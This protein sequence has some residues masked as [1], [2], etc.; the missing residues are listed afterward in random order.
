M[1][2][3]VDGLNG[4]FANV[5]GADESVGVSATASTASLSCITTSSGGGKHSSGALTGGGQ[6]KKSKAFRQPLQ[7]ARK[8]PLNASDEGEGGYYFGNMIC[9]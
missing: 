7:I 8:S 4:L 1:V 5:D 6:K 9:I 3:G 2:A